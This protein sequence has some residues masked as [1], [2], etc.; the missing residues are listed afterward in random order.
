[1]EKDLS[2]LAQIKD[3]IKKNLKKGYTKESLYWALVNQGHSK[4]EIDTAFR[5]VEQELANE[6]P[7]LKTKPKITYE[8]IHSQTGES[9]KIDIR[10]K[11][12]WKRIFD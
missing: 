3:Y 4:R 2:Y 6:A 8:R 1:M 10:K 5:K 7:I 12:F 9:E 11:A